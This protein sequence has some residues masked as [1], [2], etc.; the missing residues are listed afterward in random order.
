MQRK[1]VLLLGACTLLAGT[2]LVL[3]WAF[4]G[5]KIGLVTRETPLV[6]E[7]LDVSIN[8]SPDGSR[9]A[10]VRVDDREWLMHYAVD[11]AAAKEYDYVGRRGKKQ[12]VVVDGVEQ[13]EYDRIEIPVFSPGGE[14]FAYAAGDIGR[15]AGVVLDGA[16]TRATDESGFPTAV[17]FSPNGKRVAYVERNRDHCRVV[18]DRVAGKAYD[19]VT[20]LAFAADSNTLAYRARMLDRT[21]C[22]VVGD[23]EGTHYAHVGEPVFCPSTGKV[24]Y[25]ANYRGKWWIVV[26]GMEGAE[27]DYDNVGNG[28]P[29]FSPDGSRLAYAA[30]RGKS[31]FMVVD[32]VE[33]ERFDRITPIEFSQDGSRFLYAGMRGGKH[34]VVIDGVAGSEYDDLGHLTLTRDGARTAYLAKRGNTWLAVVD[35]VEQSACCGTHS[36]AFSPDGKH[37]AYAANYGRREVELEEGEYDVHKLP[38]YG[39]DSSG[40]PVKRGE[41]EIKMPNEKGRKKL[42]KAGGTWCVVRDGVKGPKYAMVANAAFTPDGRHLVYWAKRD[43]KWRIVVDGTEAR[44]KYDS[45]YCGRQSGL[46]TGGYYH[47]GEL[48]FTSATR[49]CFESNTRCC[50]LAKRGSTIYRAEVE[51]AAG[52]R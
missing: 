39:L 13:R 49:F 28:D 16:E 11:R 3:A 26:G 31:W 40:F 8:L 42:E 25:V 19:R 46:R 51:I 52:S 50:T 5:P 35:G 37:V 27:Y 24:A 4:R 30:A 17:T 9:V 10:V 38:D 32:G 18:V 43:G 2:V 41:S 12:L 1:K 36:L 21:E 48:V 15:W 14:H 44:E 23:A 33:G 29:V 22:V 7:Q 6:D 34:I 47:Q 45:L 20:G